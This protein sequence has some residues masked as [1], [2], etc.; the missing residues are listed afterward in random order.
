[1]IQKL[2]KGL[3]A[4]ECS[5]ELNSCWVDLVNSLVIITIYSLASFYC[6]K[7]EKIEKIIEYDSGL[8]NEMDTE[9]SHEETLGCTE[10]TQTSGEATSS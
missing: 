4:L 6:G 8:D 2:M 7:I 5:C 1:M 9:Q 3:Y 10:Q